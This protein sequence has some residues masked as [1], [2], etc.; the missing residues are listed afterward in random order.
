MSTAL[1]I[2]IPP[3]LHALAATAMLLE[4]LEHLPRGASAEQYRDLVQQLQTLLD[5]ARDDPALDALVAG[6][7]TLAEVYEN[8][9]YAQA[10]LCRSP[11]DAVADSESATREL[12]DRMRQAPAATPAG[13]ATRKNG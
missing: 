1:P 11:L 8:R 5:E 6:V 12:L 9:H 13:N 2:R 4:R 10:G 7:P 3:H